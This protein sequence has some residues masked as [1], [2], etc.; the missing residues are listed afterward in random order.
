MKSR[1]NH[2]NLLAFMLFALVASSP[3]QAMENKTASENSRPKQILEE[4]FVLINGIEQ[5][6]TIK[7][8]SS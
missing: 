6:V 1:P 2:F 3:L 5:W 7:G 8:E 4:K